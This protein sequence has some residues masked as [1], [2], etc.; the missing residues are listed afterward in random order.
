MDKCGAGAPPAAFDLALDVAR[1]E[2]TLLSVALDVDFD[3]VRTL[4]RR[5]C[6]ISR[7]LCEKWELRTPAPR[8]FDVDVAVDFGSPIGKA[9][10]DAWVTSRAFLSSLGVECPLPC[11]GSRGRWL[12]AK[13]SEKVEILKWQEDLRF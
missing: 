3:S 9:R 13:S 12:R 8:A 10:G 6:P 5:G 4:I 2:R 11:L 1:V 7:V